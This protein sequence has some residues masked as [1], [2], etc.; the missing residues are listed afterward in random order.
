MKTIQTTTA[1][2]IYYLAK[3]SKI[4]QKLLS[5]I[6]PPIEKCKDNIV[7]NLSYDTVLDF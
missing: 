7:E 4:K 1:N 3:D 2:L 5:E 6:L